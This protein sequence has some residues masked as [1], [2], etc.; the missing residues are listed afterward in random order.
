MY[1]YT[2]CVYICI[3]IYICIDTLNETVCCHPRERGSVTSGCLL[4]DGLQR[5]S[6]ETRNRHELC[7]ILFE[8]EQAT[9]ALQ[10][11]EWRTILTGWPRSDQPVPGQMAAGPD[12]S[13][14]GSGLSSG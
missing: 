8:T 13:V 9:Q 7:S 6:R 2:L 4:K 11:E 12:R 14:C 10:S 1:I 5:I 3:Y